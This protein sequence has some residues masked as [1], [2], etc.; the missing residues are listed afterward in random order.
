[1][2]ALAWLAVPAT[3]A[4]D[5]PSDTEFTRDELARLKRGELVVRPL[6]QRGASRLMVGGTSW[7]VIDASP[8]IVLQA[9]L[10]TRHYERM[11]P[12]VSEA[13]LVRVAA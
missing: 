2:L 9:L 1:M 8:E 7:Q 12:Q 4:A 3:V 6:T 5:V 11:L 13:R 10:D